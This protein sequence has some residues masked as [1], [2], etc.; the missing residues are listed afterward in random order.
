MPDS[1]LSTLRRTTLRE[2][3]TFAVAAAGIVAVTASSAVSVADDSTAPR[4]AMIA[5][6][7]QTEPAELV[8]EAAPVA[9]PVA[10]VPQIDELIAQPAPMPEPAPPVYE[11]NLDGWIRQALDIM[12]A[13]GIPGSY[14]GIHRNIL[15]ESSGNP[16]AINL[17]DSNAAKG[18]PSK[19][20]LQ[21]IDPT[22]AAYHVPGTPFD[23]WDPVANIVAACNYAA[24]RYGSMDNVNGA[25]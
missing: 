14:E 19:G 1:R 16:Q 6:Q 18:I 5:E 23:V 11:N 2:G 12:R 8:A 21:V 4:V 24:H 3:L 22:F 10:E 25:Y 15:R 17:W 20:L 13:N 7:E 9:E